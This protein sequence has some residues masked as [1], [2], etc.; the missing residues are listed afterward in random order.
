MK[1]WGEPWHVT[2]HAWKMAHHGAFGEFEKYFLFTLGDWFRAIR[3]LAR[4]FCVSLW[5]VP[6][7]PDLHDLSTLQLRGDIRALANKKDFTYAAVGRD[8]VA[9]KRVHR[10]ET[11]QTDV[12]WDYKTKAWTSQHRLPCV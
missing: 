8:I 4:P 2:E 3:Y 9:C 5:S 6:R 7:P 10:C 11:V 1:P 12:R